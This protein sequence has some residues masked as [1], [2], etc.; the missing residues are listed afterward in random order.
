[1]TNFVSLVLRVANKEHLEAFANHPLFV[2]HNSLV[3]LQRL[4]TVLHRHSLGVQ[5]RNVDGDDEA[6][7]GFIVWHH[8]VQ[9]RR[10]QNQDLEQVEKDEG[11]WWDAH[12]WMSE[13]IALKKSQNLLNLVYAIFRN[14]YFEK[15]SFL[16][17][18]LC[19]S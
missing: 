9:E 5:G 3:R 10:T 1:M 4:S 2:Y 8:G 11:S 6:S 16:L 14:G 13:A 15:I 18:I 12:L 7:H 19:I 17:G